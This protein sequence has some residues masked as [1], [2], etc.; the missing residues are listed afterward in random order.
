MNQ[1]KST[2]GNNT[3]KYRDLYE[4]TPIGLFRTSITDG[5]IL[6]CNEQ[7]AKLFGYDDKYQMINKT[8]A[9][10]Y[11][12]DGESRNILLQKLSIDGQ[13]D[14]YEARFKRKNGTTFWARYSAKINNNKGYIEGGLTDITIQKQTEV[15]LI[16]SE[17]LFQDLVENLMVG[18][19][20]VQEG[21]AVFMNPEQRRLLGSHPHLSDL[22]DLQI[23]PEDDKKFKHLCDTINSNQ[24]LPSEMA[25]RIYPHNKSN[26]QLDFKH[27]NVRT[28][29]VNYRGEQSVMINM[30]DITKI[31]KLEE[32][33]HIREKMI[34]LGHASLG[35]AHEIRSPLSGINLLIDGVRENFENPDFTDEIRDLLIEMKKASNK[36][37]LVV[38]RAL[39]FS[40]PSIPKSRLADI[41]EAIGDAISLM[42]ATLRKSNI[43]IETKKSK[44]VPLLYHDKPLIEQVI[45]GL[46]SNALTALESHQDEK[47]I[48]ITTVSIQNEVM[49]A[50][51]DSGPG[52]SE[53]IR[54]SIF[55]PFYTTEKSGTGI[56]LSI[57]QRIITNHGGRISVT[58]SDLGGAKFTLSL[59]VDKREIPR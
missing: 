19:S 21:K 20:I 22:C 25:I 29:R 33:S 10:D 23:H 1:N 9:T 48:R 51:E 42:Q 35:I 13:V 32:I 43:K 53:N 47:I 55:D 11:Y 50:V 59:P 4:N 28:K 58:D 31:K 24:S 27:V 18:I 34:S 38:N 52:I 2:S 45:S 39:D 15:A 5:K 49:I 36:I 26:D 17:R 6:E 41:S 3:E 54:Q 46:I 57:C 44:G 12:V 7:I 14:N 37:E 16:E 56:G 30:E 40:R 8:Y